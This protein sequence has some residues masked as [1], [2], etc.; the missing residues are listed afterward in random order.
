VKVQVFV[1]L[2]VGLFALGALSS[3]LYERYIAEPIEEAATEEERMF[4]AVEHLVGGFKALKLDRAK[5]DDFFENKLFPLV[6]RIRDLRKEAL[7]RI[8]ENQ[9]IQ[10]ALLLSFIGFFFLLNNDATV[11]AQV[12][13]TFL[14]LRQSAMDVIVSLPFFTEADV[15][16]RRMEALQKAVDSQP[17]QA[18]PGPSGAGEPPPA[19]E[20][21]EVRD[22]RFD[23]TDP[24]GQSTYSFG[25]ARFEIRRNQITFI[26]GG[27]GSG[28]TT[29][30]KLLLGL[31]FP[32]S[33][34]FAADGEKIAMR[35]QCHWF[36]AIFSDFHLFNGLYGVEAVDEGKLVRLL[37]EMELSSRTT[38]R[39][40]RFSNTELS[41][42]QKKRL[43]L[44][45]A[46]MEDKPIY[47]FDDSFSALDF[48]TDAALRKAL[49]QKTGDST[50]LIVTQRV[51][52]VKNA[53]QIIV[54]DRGRVVGKGK[55]HE[56]MEGCKTYQEIATSQL[57]KEELA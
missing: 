14:F 32:L 43:A 37:H 15:A 39:G 6:G 51:A 24:Q 22:I 31:Y 25:P 55:H 40:D 35:E 2:F 23:Y 8:G 5:R 17:R 44:V 42:G 26:I 16:S 54:L 57:S 53:D 20:I 48:K 27:N 7:N 46:L 12:M 36:C 1:G 45:I 29:F 19:F 34:S 33:G 41:M 4:Q 9:S 47:I 30:L 38:W 56:L 3:R 28:K 52:T 21:L 11:S 13:I 49:K 50:V 10:R 18:G